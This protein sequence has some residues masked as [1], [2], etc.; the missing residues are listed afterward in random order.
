VA[1]I[2]AANLCRWSWAACSMPYRKC[3]TSTMSL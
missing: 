1:L 3:S 2:I